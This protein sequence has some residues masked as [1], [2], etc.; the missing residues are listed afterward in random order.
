MNGAPA[1][2]GP[3]NCGKFG[4]LNWKRAHGPNKSRSQ[5]F[6]GGIE[7][8][9]EVRCT[10]LR[11][12]G[13]LPSRPIGDNKSHPTILPP[14][15]P[16]PHCPPTTTSNH[17]QYFGVPSFQFLHIKSL[18]IIHIENLRIAVDQKQSPIRSLFCSKRIDDLCHIYWADLFETSPSHRILHRLQVGVDG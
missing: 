7:V 17:L 5:E 18:K 4:S 11:A 1:S 6:P 8:P 12:V 16:F 15:R 13:R 2:G 10:H 9:L 14:A 3:Y